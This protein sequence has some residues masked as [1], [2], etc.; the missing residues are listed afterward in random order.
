MP[1]ILITGFCSLPGP[2]RAGVQLQH[3]TKALARHHKIDVLVV[4]HAEQAYVER[5]GDARILRVPISEDDMRA[6]VEAFRR[7]LRRQLDGADYDIVHFRDGWTGA[8]I[9]EMRDR[10]EYA[11]VFDA[12]RAP[13]AEAPLL[14]LE[15]GAELSHHEQQCLVQSDVVLVPNQASRDLLVDAHG[16][17]ERVFVVPPGVDVDRYDWDECTSDVATVV[18]AGSVAAGRGVR[19]LLR[20]MVYVN[21]RRRAD[22]LV[23]GH[24]RPAFR[25]SLEHA[26]N[27]LGLEGR[28][29]LLGEVEQVDMPALL[30]R[31]MVCVAPSTA[32]AATQP[33]ALFPT[34]LLE[35]MACRRAVVAPRRGT[36]KAL[37]QD[38]SNGF[39]FSPGDP[40]DLSNKILELL[41]D[42][43]RREEIAE[44]GYRFVREG[45]TAAA[46]R[47]GLRKAYS[48]LIELAPWGQ[49]ISD[50]IDE[51]PPIRRLH[52]SED[53]VDGVS[54]N[55]DEYE[56]AFAERALSGSDM[57]GVDVTRVDPRIKFSMDTPLG[58]PVVAAAWDTTGTELPG[59]QLT[60]EQTVSEDMVDE[61]IVADHPAAAAT[62]LFSGRSSTDIDEEG[63]PID[64]RPA[65][66]P[67]VPRDPEENRFVAGEVEVPDRSSD[68]QREL[69]SEG[70]FTAVSVLL[71]N[72]NDDTDG[73]GRDEPG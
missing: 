21:Q 25:V 17:P 56:P 16:R 60:Q 10:L 35:Y 7:A 58:T 29:S 32:D 18:Y 3:I 8:S 30:A 45:H 6:Q 26:I 19:V 64:V 73:A 67:A 39:L 62:R 69:E 9:L 41:E 34:K 2:N 54:D 36:A 46:T 24:I 49:K 23:A 40:V 43:A 15:I 70:S 63:T 44:K 33:M 68:L 57:T 71:G 72:L 38:G 55:T 52:L 37:I 27:E 42:S 31:A 53:M 5:Q 28:V 47:R 61:W 12:T 66:A 20:A 11:T 14:D 1:R 48:Y 65:P 4:R 59:D 22:L 50:I 51:A 13:I